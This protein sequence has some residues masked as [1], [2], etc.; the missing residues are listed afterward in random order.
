MSHHNKYGYRWKHCRKT[1]EGHHLQIKWLLLE[2]FLVWKIKVWNRKWSRNIWVNLKLYTRW[3]SYWKMFTKFRFSVHRFWTIYSTN[4][5]VFSMYGIYT[6][7]MFIKEGATWHKKYRWF[8]IQK[9][10]QQILHIL[11]FS[12]GNLQTV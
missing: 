7:S 10:E 4:R 2:I 9:I 3:N 5:H 6:K 1:V 8:L 12:S 11:F